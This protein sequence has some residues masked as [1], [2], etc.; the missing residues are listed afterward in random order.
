MKLK[1]SLAVATC[2]LLGIAASWTFLVVNYESDLGTENTIMVSDAGQNASIASDDSLVVLSFEGGA[3]D[4]SWSSVQLSIAAGDEVYSCSFGSQSTQSNLESKVTASLGADGSTFTTV[5]DATDE[6]EFTHL[7]LPGQKE[8]DEANSTVWFSK[9]DVFFADGVRWSFLEGVEFKEA[10]M[11]NSS[12]L[13][14]DTGE[15]LEWYTYDLAEHRVQPNDGVYLI[16][17]DDLMFKVQFMSYYNQADESRHPTIMVAALNETVFPA[18]L[19]SELVAPSPCLIVAQNDN[20][21]VWGATTTITLIENGVQICEMP[22]SVEIQ[23]TYE[24][25]PI[26]VKGINSIE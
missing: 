2:I 5:I 20:T 14:N 15:R 18:L 8:T 16:E 13:S 17:V 7:D 23:A 4:L 12:E 26:E 3:E 1:R 25:F 22:C 24:T 9:T 6:E 10:T 19:D 21:T 11:E